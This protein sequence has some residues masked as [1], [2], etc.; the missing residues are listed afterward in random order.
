MPVTFGLD[1]ELFT[2]GDVPMTKSEVRCVVLSKLKLHEDSIVYDIGAGTGSVAVEMAMAASRGQVYA[3]EKNPDALPLIEANKLKFKLPNLAVIPGAAPDALRE[4]PAPTHAFIGGS[5]GSM[6]G[7]I[8]ALLE[9]NERVRIVLTA[10]TLESLSD[11]LGCAKEFGFGHFEAIQISVAK[12]RKA[13]SYNMMMGQ[14]PVYVITMAM[15]E[16]DGGEL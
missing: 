1:D 10:I 2:R 3:I 14:N 8:S 6:R 12:S 16:H 15:S 7:I 13:G 9:K 4:L 5:S 11:A